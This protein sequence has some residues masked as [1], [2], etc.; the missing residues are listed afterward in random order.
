MTAWNKNCTCHSGCQCCCICDANPD[1]AEPDQTLQAADDDVPPRVLAAEDRRNFRTLLD[2]SSIG[3]G[4]RRMA[5]HGVDAEADHV[6]RELERIG[7]ELDRAFGDYAGSFDAEPDPAERTT[8]I[9]RE[10]TGGEGDQP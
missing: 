1:N 5:E 3:K 10:Q 6:S 9:R 8:D 4:L 7:P 2:Q